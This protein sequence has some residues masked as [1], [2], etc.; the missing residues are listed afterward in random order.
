MPIL[1]L[2]E[3]NG[4]EKRRKDIRK[5]NK[6]PST[7][8][9]TTG[10]NTLTSQPCYNSGFQKTKGDKERNNNLGQNKL[11]QRQKLKLKKFI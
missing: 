11:N 1:S 2:E 4:N 8:Q 6:Q 5:R 10:Q 9:T 7:E 3:K